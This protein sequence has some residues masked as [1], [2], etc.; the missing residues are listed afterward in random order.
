L[1]ERIFVLRAR[2]Q[3]E[4]VSNST[5]T[6]RQGVTPAS[7][8]DTRHYQEPSSGSETVASPHNDLHDTMQE[9]SYLS[10]AAMAERTDRQPFPTE[11]L[12]FLTLLYAA[13]GV[14]GE[15]PVHSLEQNAALSGPLA[16]FSK[17]TVHGN[18]MRFANATL[19]SQ[20]VEVIQHSYPFMTSVELNEMFEMVIRAH[21][22]NDTERLTAASPETIVITY[23]GLATAVLLS[24]GYTYKEPLAVDFVAHAVEL[25]SRVFDHANDISIVR[26]LTAL[27]VYSMYTTFGGSTWHLLGLTMTR[28]VASGMHTNRVS[29]PNDF[30]NEEKQRCCRTFWVLYVLDTYI[31][32]TLDRP[33]CLSDND[34]MVSPPPA[35]LS[36]EYR[37]LH[38]LVEH[39]QLLRSMRQQPDTDAWIH[40]INL[41]HWQ[42]NQSEV[43][44]QSTLPALLQSRLNVRGLVELMKQPSLRSSP[45]RS[46]ILHGSEHDFTIFLDLLE[47]CLLRQSGAS[48]P[49]DAF[50]AFAAAIMIMQLPMRTELNAI[51]DGEAASGLVARQRSISQAINTLTVL[52][53]R[54]PPIRDLREVL[55]EYQAVAT[56]DPRLAALQHLRELIGRSEIMISSQLKS[57]I[58]GEQT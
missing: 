55:V 33:F 53:V 39:A 35:D 9:A 57:L 12:S 31:S 56:R 7:Q 40:Y 28:C 18:Y 5:P 47:D 45:Q 48:S 2:V 21:Q 22:T 44:S 37:H 58:L 42:A 26:C 41:G 19:F 36:D 13:I 50:H 6:S 30:D 23:V 4:N 15:N 51:M 54:Y 49:F 20:Y 27:A 29:D 17:N 1:K 32:S 14:S 52:S 3:E 8:D 11:G 43:Q 16:D 38:S 25:L 46:M 24:P 10:L 34:V